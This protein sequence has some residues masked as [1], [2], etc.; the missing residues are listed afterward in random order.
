MQ[1]K[2]YVYGMKLRGF[3]LGAQ[4]MKGLIRVLDKALK[5]DLDSDNIYH[6]LIEYDRQ[7]TKKEIEIYDL[8]KAIWYLQRELE[9]GK[10]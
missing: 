2:I 10:D 8:E 4:P 3:S 5:E 6:D 7:L 9:N 1:Q